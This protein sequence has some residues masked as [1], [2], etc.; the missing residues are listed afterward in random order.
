MGFDQILWG[1]WV[2]CRDDWDDS[3]NLGNSWLCVSWCGAASWLHHRH[4][5]GPCHHTQH[6]LERSSPNLFFVP[7]E[8][9]S[10]SL[11]HVLSCC[12]YLHIVHMIKEVLCSILAWCQY[13][14]K[15]RLDTILDIFILTKQPTVQWTLDLIL[16]RVNLQIV[17]MS[18]KNLEILDIGTFQQTKLPRQMTRSTI[19]LPCPWHQ[20]H[21]EA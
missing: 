16:Q 5:S 4:H 1:E 9:A 3:H 2:I 18:H 7:F 15:T 20:T 21:I 10:I 11:L 19:K 17:N 12:W 6:T 14:L 8:A 13:N